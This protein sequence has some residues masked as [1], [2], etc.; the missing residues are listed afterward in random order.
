MARHALVDISQILNTA[1]DP[2]DPERLS[3]E[4]LARLRRTL[5]SSGL[6]LRDDAEADARLS[7]LRAMYEPYVNSL[8]CYLLMTLPPWIVDVEKVDNWRTSAWGRISSGLEPPAQTE[9]QDEEHIW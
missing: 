8:S 3:R 9:E 2:P 5:R 4:D 6:T 1:P 7:S